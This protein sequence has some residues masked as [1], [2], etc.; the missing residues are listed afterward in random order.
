MKKSIELKKK[1]IVSFITHDISILNFVYH[2]RTKY[3]FRGVKNNRFVKN[4][5]FEDYR[6]VVDQNTQS[7]QEL[8]RYYKS[9]TRKMKLNHAFANI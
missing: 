4:G 8:L 5:E 2:E 9:T 3:Q 6:V 1:N 7:Y